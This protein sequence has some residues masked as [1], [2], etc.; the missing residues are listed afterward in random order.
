MPSEMM[1]P[2]SGMPNSGMPNSGMPISGP[3]ANGGAFTGTNGAICAPLMGQ[4]GGEGAKM[5]CCQEG[6]CVV[7]SPFVSQCRD[8][9]SKSSDDSGV[10]MQTVL[11]VVFV[12]FLS[13][14]CCGTLLVYKFCIAKDNDGDAGYYKHSSLSDRDH[15]GRYDDRH[16]RRRKDKKHRSRDDSRSRTRKDRD[17]RTR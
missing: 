17:R 7:I 16:E 14:L 3:G 1:A 13:A 10:S 15:R 12:T 2:N 6:E 4:C 9:G 5:N 11:I 8:L